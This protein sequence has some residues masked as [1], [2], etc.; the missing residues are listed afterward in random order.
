MVIDEILADLE[1]EGALATRGKVR[2]AEMGEKG[3]VVAHGKFRIRRGRGDRGHAGRER[4]E[5]E[6]DC[7]RNEGPSPERPTH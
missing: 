7:D 3:R 1:A 6:Q 4:D 5:P 2:A